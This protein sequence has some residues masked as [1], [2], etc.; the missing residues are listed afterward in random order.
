MEA[1]SSLQETSGIRAWNTLENTS[2][3]QEERIPKLGCD[4]LIKDQFCTFQ[5]W[6]ARAE[7]YRGFMQSNS[8][9]LLFTY[10]ATYMSV[11]SFEE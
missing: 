11:T 6:K 4:V 3:E 9:R 7:L 10:A 2:P 8:L 1:F 5:R